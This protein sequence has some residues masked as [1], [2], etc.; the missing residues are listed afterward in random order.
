MHSDKITQAWRKGRTSTKVW[1]EKA[2]ETGECAI[3]D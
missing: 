3:S 1:G 2:K